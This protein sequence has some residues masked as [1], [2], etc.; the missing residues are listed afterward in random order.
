MTRPLVPGITAILLVM[1]AGLA[2]STPEATPTLA[3]RRPHE[4]ASA[5]G[6]RVDA[7]YWLR[8][9]TRSR[10]D[11]LGH[12]RAENAYY[13]A[14]SAP[15]RGLVA[16]LEKELVGRLKQ[17]DTSVPYKY[18][19]S[20]YY[21]RFETGKEYP[22]YAR[23]GVGASAEQVLV[24]ANREAEGKAFYQVGARAVSARQ[25]KVAF[26]E[27]A[28]GRRQYTLRIRDIA[29]GKDLGERIAGLSPFAAWANDDKTVYYVEN[30]PVTLLSTRVRKH[31]LGADPKT[32]PVVYEE[33]DTS[34]Y[35]RLRKSGD[36]RF[37][38]IV[39]SSTVSTELRVIDADDPGGPT[40]V[41]AP[42]ER[43]HL[44]SADHL[45][46][47][48]VVKTNLA[49][50]NYR[51][52]AVADGD[53]GDKARWK[54]VLPY[55]SAVF[56]EDFALFR[57][58]LAINERAGGL[59]RIRVVPWAAP[60]KAFVVSADEPAYAEGL[61]DNHEPDTDKLRYT[62]TSLTTPRSVFEVDMGT[63]ERTLLKREPVLGGFDAA[64]YVTERLWAPARDG[65]KVPVSL[66]Y[67]KG[68]KKDGSAP[69]YQTAYG[70]YGSSSD[71][72]FELSAV[73]LLDRGF[74][75]AIAHVRG[76]QELGRAWYDH[77]RLLEKR[78]TFTDF[79][80]VTA[81]LVREK[82][83]SKD[84]VC[85]MGISAGG[86]LMGSIANMAP[87]TYRAI[88]A[89]VPFVD[90]VTTMLDE[91]IPLTS[92][93]WDE[94]GDP[95]QKP[96]YDYILS[97][98]PYDNVTARAYPALFVTTSLDDSQVQ[99][100]EPA[101][102]VAKL[103]ATKTDRNP[104]LFKVNMAGGHGGKSGRFASLGET[105]EEYAFLLN[106]LGMKE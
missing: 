61:S 17:D 68:L 8:D 22:V 88:V 73:S 59:L 9:D 62:Y 32:D 34:F 91:T 96:D 48:W 39:L 13:E 79:I 80:D 60:A 87:E 75:Y 76:G 105:A 98:S 10:P 18:K 26:L 70:A 69:L 42:R 49:A 33:K 84:K 74:V 55:D 28:V 37:V 58:H 45:A 106:L 86:L 16:K 21:T 65:T 54:E 57:G 92:N 95:R 38:M 63:G 19:D 46:G 35:L 83:A 97:Y 81:F 72:E 23:R 20:L 93:E 77:G 41:L 64:H 67:R 66:V 31:T 25:D 4:V 40:R 47:R 50:P 99:Y 56:V 89:H 101:K 3:E 51:L 24:D 78:N 100:Y 82:Y 14:M 94:W 6:T 12:L 27:D 43:D 7:Y 15:Y 103:R 44:Y 1:G 90:A 71:P 85:A 5:H 102:W 2:T 30:D 53:I 29:S 52:M 11:V 36:D 104:L